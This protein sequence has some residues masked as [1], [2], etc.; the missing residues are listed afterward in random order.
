MN[1]WIMPGTGTQGGRRET[2]GRGDA[3]KIRQQGRERKHER[4]GSAKGKGEEEW[5]REKLN[6]KMTMRKITKRKNE[7]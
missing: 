3:W 6:G 7:E 4:S 1:R 5:N 2:K